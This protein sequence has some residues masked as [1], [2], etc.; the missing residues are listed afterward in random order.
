M[1]GSRW[2]TLGS[3]LMRRANALEDNQA[4]GLAGLSL[5]R[6]VRV[7][8]VT[9]GKGGVGKTNV[10]LNLS[11]ALSELGQEV[12]LLDADLGLANVDVLLG[13]RP[14]HNLSHVLD[15]SVEL[16][17]IV[18]EGPAGV[19]I[20]PGASG[21][22]RMAQLSAP[23]HAGLIQAFGEI[24]IG[25]D[26]LIVDTTAGI[27]ETV[28]AFT[29]A[30][31]EIVVVVCDEPASLTDAYAL[32]KVLHREHQ[33]DRFRVVCNQCR[34]PAEGRTL[35]T[36]LL[37]VCERYLDVTLEFAGQV[38][39]DEYLRKA[40]QMQRP[41]VHAYPASPAGQAFKKL[42]RTADKWP[43]PGGAS[44]R[45]EFFVERLVGA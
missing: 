33:R 27:S 12:M 2:P 1:S 5:S 37:R 13:L 28:V 16:S 40:V 25:L 42:A 10:S 44:G 29:K 41:V 3:P 8:S 31:Q 30:S 4:A 20:V 22:Q 21:L 35:Y 26:T 7:I 39:Y 38:P 36:K 24:G 45:L 14:M 6:P 34:G 43:V 15:G 9:G 11:I 19:R 32:I 23:E 18:L 17:N